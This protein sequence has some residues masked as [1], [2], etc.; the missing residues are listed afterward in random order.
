MVWDFIFSVFPFLRRSPEIVDE[1]DE[2][3][4]FY[5]NFDYQETFDPKEFEFDFFANIYNNTPI[6]EKELEKT[7]TKYFYES[8]IAK[9]IM[10]FKGNSNCEFCK[11][12]YDKHWIRLPCDHYIHK[13]CFKEIKRYCPK[14]NTQI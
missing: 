5:I 12:P 6:Q 8:G 4:D 14:C 7:L 10:K 9:I 3:E 13:Y 1:E 2:E 11:Q